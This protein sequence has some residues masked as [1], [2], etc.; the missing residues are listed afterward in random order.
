VV[1][2][3]QDVVTNRLNICGTRYIHNGIHLLINSELT[4]KSLN[5]TGS[6]WII[7]FF[8]TQSEMREMNRRQ[9]V[10]TTLPR[11]LGHS[12]TRGTKSTVTQKCV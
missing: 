9:M 7:E 4:D 12:I 11:I 6:L 10:A 5:L 1:P 3:R 8:I 2:E